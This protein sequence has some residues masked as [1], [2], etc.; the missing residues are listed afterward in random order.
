MHD[1]EC[2]QEIAEEEDEEGECQHKYLVHSEVRHP[3]M[4]GAGEEGEARVNSPVEEPASNLSPR[5]LAQP[6]EAPARHG[7]M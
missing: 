6:W 1:F 4:P 3:A 7:G 2:S 5:P